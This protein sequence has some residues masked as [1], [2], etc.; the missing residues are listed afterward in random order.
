MVTKTSVEWKHATSL[1]KYQA[2]DWASKV[3]PG[4]PAVRYG[5]V[6]EAEGT[7]IVWT[8]LHTAMDA[9]TRKLLCDDL[10][11]FLRNTEDF[12]AKPGRPTYKSYLDH[13]SRM[14]AGAGRAFWTDYLTGLEKQKPLTQAATEIKEPV[15][16]KRIVEYYPII[17]S[18]KSSIRLSTVAHVAF[19]LVL[20]C[21]TGSEDIA[22][23]TVRGSRTLFPG[24]EAIMG[25]LAKAISL[26]IRFKPDDTIKD[27]LQKVQDES[28]S[29]MRHEPFHSSPEA[30]SA[31]FFFNWYPR[32]IDL[33]TR[34]VLG[35][36]KDG[37]EGTL[38]IIDQ[39]FSP[40][41]M[42]GIFGCYDNGES[43]RLEVAYDD[44]VYDD[45]FV[46]SFVHSFIELMDGLRNV[47]QTTRL[48]TLL[49]DVRKKWEK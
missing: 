3:L 17:R 9:W 47:D 49:F 35:K 37:H 33:H 45:K 44:R 26:R 38:K 46:Q 5:L 11:V 24:A 23:A 1:D 29:M 41:P 10:E 42:A 19:G 28:T 20:G 25:T 43:L 18:Q 8:A 12:V 15:V 34:N 4:Q 14:D 39:R 36:D 22:Y 16:N 2:D 21:I 40:H 27:L 6:K 32:G 48:G 7:F 13:V 31:K 30:M